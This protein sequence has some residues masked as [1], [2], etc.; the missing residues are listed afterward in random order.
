MAALLKSAAVSLSV[1][2][3]RY[4]AEYARFGELRR[5]GHEG[6]WTT[7]LYFLA[8]A[9]LFTRIGRLEARLSDRNRPRYVMPR[10]KDGKEG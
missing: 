10:K 5:D 6:D 1:V 4:A 3:I 2:A 8:M 9:V 7:V